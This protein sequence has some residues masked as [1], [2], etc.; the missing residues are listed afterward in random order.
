MQKQGQAISPVIYHVIFGS[1]CSDP[2]GAVNWLA[3]KFP[4]VESKKGGMCR[5]NKFGG[6]GYS[7][8]RAKDNQRRRN[9]ESGYFGQP[10]V[11]EGGGLDVYETL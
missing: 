11:F 2:W 7:M 9:Q 6:S 10:K 1:W 5:R 8:R 4:G 3:N